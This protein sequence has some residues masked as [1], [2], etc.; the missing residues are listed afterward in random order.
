MNEPGINESPD[1]VAEGLA[2]RLLIAN[3][4]KKETAA[5]VTA[6]EKELAELLTVNGD[7]TKSAEVLGSYKT[8]TKLN[9]SRSIDKASYDQLMAHDAVAATA[10]DPALH[11]LLTGL[12]RTKYELELKNLRKLQQ[13]YPDWY[14][15]IAACVSEKPGKITVTVA[16]A[17]A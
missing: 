17:E 8:E 4:A 11:E 9:I 14:A 6:I 10:S 5:V 1:L 12:V 7:G 13:D 15:Y 2:E 16:E 3:R